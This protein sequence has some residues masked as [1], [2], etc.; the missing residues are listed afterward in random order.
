ML[1]LLLSLLLLAPKELQTPQTA[2]AK[3]TGKISGRVTDAAT[4]K[5]LSVATLRLVRWEGGRGAQSSRPTDTDG[6]FAFTDLLPGSYQLSAAAEG[7][8]YVGLDFGQRLPTEPGRRIEL[9]DGQQFDKADFAL[10][11]TGAIE[12]RLVDEFGDP[13]PGVTVQIA[14]VMFAAGKRRLMPVSGGPI[15]TRPTD[16]LGQFRVFNLSPGDYYVLALSGPFAG[17]DDPSGFAPTYFPGTRVA[18]QAQPVHVG[19]ADEVRGVSFGLVP[20]SMGTVAGSVVDAAGQPSGGATVL[21][22]QTTGGDVRAMI[23]ARLGTA[24]DG[25]FSF[26]NVAPGSYVIQAFGRPQGSGSIAAGAF[27]SLVLDVPDGGIS[28]LVLRTASSMARG[29]ISFEGQAPLPNPRIVTVAPG[30]VEFVTSPVIGGGLPPS[31]TH[32][33]WTFEVSNMNG[34]RVIRVNV[35]APG[36]MLKR[37]TLDG[38]D[39]TDEPVDFSKG[40]V[41]GLEITL[42]SSAA[43]VTGTVTDGGAPA[44]GYAVLVFSDDQTKWTFPSRHIAIGGPNQQGTFRV[45]GL[46]AGSYRVIAL[47]AGEVADAQDPESLTKLVPLSTGVIVGE[48]ETQTVTLKLIKR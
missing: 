11:R 26:R 43:S 2:P 24:A 20:A 46:P 36:W 45:T 27:G 40:D 31:V 44:T 6:R 17:A 33:D 28:D 14:R 15:A 48:G 32:D 10:S 18:T 47:P 37:V 25:A 21:L 7:Y 22:L 23:M 41:N 38:R 9:G 3:G 29:H 30:Q 12:G 42:T 8:G 1:V 19:Y 5:P 34:R 16:D 39:I 13:M 4:G 35:G